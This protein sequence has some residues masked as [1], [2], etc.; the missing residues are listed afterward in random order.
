MVLA[1]KGAGAGKRA[2]TSD[3]SFDDDLAAMLA[4]TWIGVVNLSKS[5]HVRHN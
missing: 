2:K 5:M 4:G 3:D 1:G